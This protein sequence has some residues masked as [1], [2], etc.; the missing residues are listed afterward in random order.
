M[1]NSGHKQGIRLSQD[2]PYKILP[3]SV[4]KKTVKNKAE[5]EDRKEVKNA[6]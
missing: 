3:L 4:K 1:V 6:A 2:I 5:K